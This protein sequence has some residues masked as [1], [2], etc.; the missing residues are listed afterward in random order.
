MAAF[1]FSAA[2]AAA[3]MTEGNRRPSPL[4][5]VVAKLQSTRAASNVAA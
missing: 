3:S 1:D 4:R 5:G 2:Q